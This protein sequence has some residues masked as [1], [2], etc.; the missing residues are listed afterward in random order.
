[1]EGVTFT[2]INLPSRPDRRAAFRARVEN[3]AA[4]GSAGGTGSAGSVRKA[5][6]FQYA[7]GVSHSTPHVGCGLAHARAVRRAFADPAVRVAVVLEDDACLRT[8]TGVSWDDVLATVEHAR[9]HMNDWDVL[10]LTVS[11]VPTQPLPDTVR[12]VARSTQHAPLFLQCSPSFALVNCTATAWT[13]GAL[14]FLA[15]YVDE[16]EAT[17]ASVPID[18]VLYAQVLNAWGP[19]PSTTRP[20]A[21]TGGSTARGDASLGAAGFAYDAELT[22]EGLHRALPTAAVP[23]VWISARLLFY[24]DPGDVSDNT[25][26]V[27]LDSRPLDDKG[28]RAL[29]RKASA[30]PTHKH[31]P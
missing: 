26:L 7:C 23:R 22:I 17:Q 27:T 8:D 25:G 10:A 16:L 29:L 11:V 13:R 14:P 28:M 6:V 31:K 24:Q 3:A 20:A 21:A 12:V 19:Q 2:V 15:A 30:D 9:D 1:M 5:P 4:A 18:R